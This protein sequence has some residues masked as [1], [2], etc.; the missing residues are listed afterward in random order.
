M[1]K[2]LI[3]AKRALDKDDHARSSS[4]NQIQQSN[5]SVDEPPPSKKKRLC[6]YRPEY[7]EEFPF[8]KQSRRGENFVFCEHCK[9]DLNIASGG[10]DDLNKHLKTIKH[11]E[12]VKANVNSK[13]KSVNEFFPASCDLDV[14]RAEVKVT[15]FLMDSNVPLAVSDKFNKLVADI[16]PDSKIATKYQCGRTKATA[17][18]HTLGRDSME[19]IA[20]IL[21]ENLFALST[22]GSNNHDFKLYPIVVRVFDNNEGL[23][24]TKLSLP[25]LQGPSTAVNIKNLILEQLE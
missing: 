24:M 14:I 19:S 13:S 18:S 9:G 3:K 12:S 22:D 21:R 15:K 1:D 10:R 5:K 4:S 6:R 20:D 8:I 25:E 16:F 11:I 7:S 2:F 17:I 23:V